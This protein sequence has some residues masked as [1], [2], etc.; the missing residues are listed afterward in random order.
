[1]LNGS[2]NPNWQQM[3]RRNQAAFD[4]AFRFPQAVNG[5]QFVHAGRLVVHYAAITQ[6]FATTFASAGRL[7]EGH[8]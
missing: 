2:S 6:E 4:V 3:R 7:S 8:S 1:M 5:P